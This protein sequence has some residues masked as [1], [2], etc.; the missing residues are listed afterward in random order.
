[1]QAEGI[2]TKDLTTDMN[3]KE[4]TNVIMGF[5]SSYMFRPG[6]IQPLRGI[7]SKTKLYSAMYAI[8]G[9]LYW[10]I[11]KHIP[12]S[13]SSTTAIGKAMINAAIKQPEI[14]ILHS[15]EINKLAKD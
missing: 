12:G 7:K 14:R 9:P 6:Y 1:M 2:K 13:A 8:S 3:V 10:L 4:K 15:R 11:L 5:K